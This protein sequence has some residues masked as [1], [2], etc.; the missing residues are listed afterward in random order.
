MNHPPIWA[1]AT[2]GPNSYYSHRDYVK[3]C[4]NL[5]QLDIFSHQQDIVENAIVYTL[6]L[7]LPNPNLNYNLQT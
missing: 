2:L 5:H 6:D 1:L 3:I 4:P 7:T